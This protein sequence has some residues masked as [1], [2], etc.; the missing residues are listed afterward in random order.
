MTRQEFLKTSLGF[1]LGLP[2][3]SGTLLG[4]CAQRSFSGQ[5]ITPNFSGKVIVVGAGAA[6]LTAGYLL[7]HYGVEVQLLE[8]APIYGGRLKKAAHFADFPID[9]G[10]EWLHTDPAVLTEIG[11]HLN[12]KPDR[13]E[14]MEYNPRAIS[15]W[16]NGKLKRHNYLRAV[17]SE[18][19]FRES[20]WF[21]FFEQY[22]VPQLTDELILN[23][24]VTSIDYTADQV[25]LNTATGQR[26]QADKVLI[27]VPLTILQQERIDFTPALPAAK[28]EAIS[29]VSMG[30]GIKVFIAFKTKFYPD[31]LTFGNIFKAIRAEEKLFYDAAFGKASKDNILGLF[32]INKAA[33]AYTKLSSEQ[34]IIRKILGELDAIF[35]GKASP[36]Y[37]RHIVQNWSAEPYIR[38]AYSYEF[39]ENQWDTVSLLSRPVADKLYFAG[40]ALSVENQ[41]MVHGACE[42]AYAAVAQVLA[43]G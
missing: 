43:K 14:V 23:T 4:G 22:F 16:K 29:Q 5:A 28:K 11:Q 6:G 41:A 7:K 9:L 33:S 34:E 8:A 21:D 17:Y 2:L 40:E 13:S 31:V 10:A 27:T 38:G 39:T 26:Y 12:P 37:L 42:S 35:E 30:D 3:L 24:P 19:K 18:W 20:T 32:T 25:V 15:T 36:N 1:G